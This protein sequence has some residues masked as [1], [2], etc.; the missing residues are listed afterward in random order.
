VSADSAAAAA[1]GGGARGNAAR[2]AAA[3]VKV[4]G[5]LAKQLRGTGAPLAAA[6][7]GQRGG[8]L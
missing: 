2:K 1:R 6:P 5:G 3:E 8:G 4:R 7:R